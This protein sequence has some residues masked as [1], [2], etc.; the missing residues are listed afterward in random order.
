[1]RRMESILLKQYRWWAVR[2]GESVEVVVVAKP[3]NRVEEI[4][5]SLPSISRYFNLQRIPIGVR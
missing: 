3:S 1:M 4:L 2:A 5:G